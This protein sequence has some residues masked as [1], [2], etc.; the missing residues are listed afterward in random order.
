MAEEIINYNRLAPYIEERGKQLLQ[1]TFG[2]ASATQQTGESNADFQARKLGR[3]GVAQQVPAFQV[4]G[5]D[6]QQQ[7]ARAMTSQGIGQYQP[8]LNQAAGTINQGVQSIAGSQGM[9]APTAQGIQSYM[10]P[11]QQNVTQNALAELDRQGQLQQQGINAQQVGAGAFGSERAGIQ[12]AELGRNLQDIKS[13]RIFED[14][15]RNFQ[16]AQQ[17]AQQ[18]F[19]AQQGR[20][21]NAGQMLGQLGGQQ[22]GIGQLGQNLYGQDVTNL[23]TSGALGQAQGQNALEAQRQTQLLQNQEPFQRLSFASGILTGTPASQ[24]TVQQQPSTTPFLQV[25][26]LGI[27]GLGAYKGFNTQG[28]NALVGQ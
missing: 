6:A 14:M 21:A 15:S 23:L 25:A 4:Q 26:G 12:N 16:Q 9:F 8:Y 1:S 22:A 18:S 5:L 17:T 27:M 20:Q 13:K 11:Y 2:D 19:E 10:D 24:M 3:A 7:Q 28:A